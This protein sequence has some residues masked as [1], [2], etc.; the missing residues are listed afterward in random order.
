MVFVGS[1]Q[2]IGILAFSLIKHNI[3]NI[4]ENVTVQS[5]VDEK[6]EEMIE[7]LNQLN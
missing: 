3:F 5:L 7:F 2:F 6:K 1:M 4:K